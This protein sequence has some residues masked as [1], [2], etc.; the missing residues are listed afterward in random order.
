M[1]TKLNS[2]GLIHDSSC[3]SLALAVGSQ[4]ITPVHCSRDLGVVLDDK[5]TLDVHAR[6]VAR[7][8]FYQLRQLRSI[9]RS[10]TF[11]AR[12]APVTAFNAIFYYGVAATTMRRLQVCIN[13][14][15]RLVT[16]VG[17]YEHITPVQQDILHCNWTTGDLQNCDASV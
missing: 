14:A 3:R 1:P 16:G 11:V 4:H 6:N 8:C 9:R 2:S 12:R 15:A 7:S 13:A 5:L 10:L 17:K